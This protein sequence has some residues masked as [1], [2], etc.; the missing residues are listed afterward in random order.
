VFD[1]GLLPPEINSGRMYA[2]PGSAPMLAAA[3]A[4]DELGA[5]LGT[6]SSGYG[7]VISELTSAAWVGP[8][9]SSMVAAVVPYVTWL[10]AAASLAEETASQARSAAAAF[11]AAFAMTVPPPVIAFNRAL[12]MTL[13]AT[14]FFGQNSP[15]I[16]ATEAQYMEMWAQDATAMY[17]YTASSAT[18]SDLNPFSSPPN[19]TMSNGAAGQTAAVAQATAMQAESTSQTTA[20]TSQLTSAT[21]ASQVLQGLSS[22]GPLSADLSSTGL[23]WPLSLLP[24]PLTSWW[25][26]NNTDYTTLLHNVF[27]IYNAYGVGNNAWS[28]AQQLTYGPGG[29]TAGSGGAWYPTP[30]F[31]HLGW[32]KHGAAAASVGQAG[33]VGRLSVPSHWRGPRPEDIPEPEEIEEIEEFPE[34]WPVSTSPASSAIPGVDSAAAH[35]P[36]TTVNGNEVL[37][38]LPARL[39]GQ[40]TAG[41]IHKYG[42]RYSV[43]ARPPSGG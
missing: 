15:A 8:S 38:G 21:T 39:A 24:T 3:T 40:P 7:S 34:N 16:A 32:A 18:A 27:Q 2:G 31:G 22:T 11:D 4:W 13:T 1:Y 9:S 23:P 36:A 29:T 25:Q 10:G 42:W 12:L 19:T 14:N 20:T 37:G 17:G 33:R 5:E 41:Y 6:A 26:L 35:A 28:I 43:V 30:Q